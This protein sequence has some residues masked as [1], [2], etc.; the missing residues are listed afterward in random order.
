MTKV[1]YESYYY[2]YT[3]LVKKIKQK[4]NTW[5]K[6]ALCTSD[7]A[8]QPRMQAREQDKLEVCNGVDLMSREYCIPP[9]SPD[10]HGDAREGGGRGEG[11]STLPTDAY[12]KPNGAAVF[13]RPSAWNRSL[14]VSPQTRW[15][16]VSDLRRQ[17]CGGKV[18]SYLK[19][20]LSRWFRYLG[21]S[22]FDKDAGTIFCLCL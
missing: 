20:H 9:R 19:S 1:A 22:L 10:Y 21:L 5:T 6:V 15:R 17:S 3:K 7:R 13:V 11:G 4:Q 2:T 14:L 18:S 8:L 12:L 16:L